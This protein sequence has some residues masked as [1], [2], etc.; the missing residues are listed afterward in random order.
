T[1]DDVDTPRVLE[2]Q[3]RHLTQ[4]RVPH[5]VA[6]VVVDLFEAVQIEE[7]QGHRVVEAP[8]ACYF[9]FETDRE[10]AAVVEAG[11]LVLGG[12]FLEAGGGRLE[13]AGGRGGKRGGLVD[14][15]RPRL[16]GGG[17]AWGRAH[18]DPQSDPPF[19]P[20]LTRRRGWPP[21]SPPSAGR[22][23]QDPR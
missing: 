3:L 11:H 13:V 22:W 16:G 21:L 14:L 19:P 20:P 17:D 23:R 10:E 6:E 2:E 4:R 12:D 1:A 7:D 5:R 18:E 15:A 8:V 9:L